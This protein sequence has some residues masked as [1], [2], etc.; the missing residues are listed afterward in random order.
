ML[1]SFLFGYGIGIQEIFILIILGV[2]VFFF[3]K[4]APKDGML[5]KIMAAEKALESEGF[6]ISRKVGVHTT[7]DG[8]LGYYLYVDDVNKKWLMTSYYLAERGEIRSYE[9]I[10]DYDVFDEDYTDIPGKIATGLISATT[11][12]GGLAIGGMYGRG[13]LGA[14]IGGYTGS[15][16]GKLILNTQ[17]K[18]RAYGLA[19][20]INDL[21]NPVIDF[22]FC[23]VIR[24]SRI[25]NSL[26]RTSESRNGSK[27]IRDMNAIKQMADIFDYIISQSP[28][29]KKEKNLSE[30]DMKQCPYCSEKILATA[31]KCKHCGEWFE[32]K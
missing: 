21:K 9:D 24:Y 20:R 4:A 1:I 7:W 19:L 3:L 11:A 16:A 13:L 23:N 15:K 12:V 25:G 10:F 31:K 28:E 22:D 5:K 18:S 29:L 27:Y 14:A 26:G 17:G 32:G 2:I 8:A 6:V 30:L